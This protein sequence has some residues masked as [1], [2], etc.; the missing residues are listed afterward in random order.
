MR[1]VKVRPGFGVVASAAV[2]MSV[3]FALAGCGST[4]NAATTTASTTANGAS[5][6]VKAATYNVK[7]THIA[8]ASGASDAAG[9]AVLTIKSPG[10]ELC[11]SISPV[12]GFTVSSG[13]GPPTFATIQP[14]SA[15]TPRIPGVPLGSPRGPKGPAYTPSGCAHK[16]VVFLKA[17]EAHPQTYYLSIFNT[18]SGEAVHGQV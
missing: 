1:V 14:T 5:S 9:V 6:P 10:D 13:T 3:F 7:L 11:W 4:N 16:P 15:G 8:G 18:K 2:G 17:L 12:K